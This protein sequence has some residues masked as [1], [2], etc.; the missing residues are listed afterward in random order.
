MALCPLR[1]A[2]NARCRLRRRRRLQGRGKA[3]LPR[4][5]AVCRRKA[6]LPVLCRYRQAARAPFGGRAATI[7]QKKDTMRRCF[8]PAGFAIMKT[9]ARP[10][11]RGAAAKRADARPGPV[12]KGEDP[13]ATTC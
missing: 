12:K 3:A 1:A 8:C 7:A 2:E 10:P 6:R 4:P 9:D 5:R 13:Y 11:G